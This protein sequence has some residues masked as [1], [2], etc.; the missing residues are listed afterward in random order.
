MTTE[1][2][3]RSSR[4]LGNRDDD[5][6]YVFRTYL[7][8][9]ILSLPGTFL[10]DIPVESVHENMGLTG[11]RSMQ[12]KDRPQC[13]RAAYGAMRSENSPVSFRRSLESDVDSLLTVA[14]SHPTLEQQVLSYLSGRTRNSRPE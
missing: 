6:K 9:H 5:F 8:R 3:Y 7:L 12:R 1:W 2:S 11:D 13:E 14:L 10:P 4:R